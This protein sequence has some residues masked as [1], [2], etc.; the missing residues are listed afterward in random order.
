MA[1]TTQKRGRGRPP[2]PKPL[3]V[4]SKWSL[5]FG[6]IAYESGQEYLGNRMVGQYTNWSSWFNTR[7]YTQKRRG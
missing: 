6:L 7:Y 3:E 2:K 1:G 4:T 5:F